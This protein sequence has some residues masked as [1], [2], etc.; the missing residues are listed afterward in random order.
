MADNEVELLRDIKELLK[1]QNRGGGGGSRG[2]YGGGAAAP[3]GGGGG[4]AI[5]GLAGGATKVVGGLDSLWRGSLTVSTS[6]DTL[7]KAIGNAGGTLG[8][9]FGKIASDV[10]RTMLD[11]NDAV[12]KSVKQGANFNNDLA[13]YDKLIKGARMTH[14]EYND[15][16]KKGA[17]DMRGLG[18]NINT[19]QK[20]FLLMAKAFQEGDIGARLKELGMHAEDLNE[21]MSATMTN[22]RG[23][24]M[25]DPTTKKSAIES[26]ER[27]LLATEE[28]ARLTGES[29]KDQLEAVKKHSE[30]AQMQMKLSMMDKQ[31]RE[32]YDAGMVKMHM[33]GPA[34]EKLYR[35]TFLGKITKEGQAAVTATG[36]SAAD[37]QRFAN[38][39]KDASPEGKAQAEKLGNTA[40]AKNIE[41]QN[42]VG[43]KN[44][45]MYSEGAGADM[46][47][48]QWLG[49]KIREPINAKIDEAKNRGED[50]DAATAYK[51]MTDAERK[52]MAPKS[53]E[54]QAQQTAGTQVATTI[55]KGD[56]KLS[57]L[58]AGSTEAFGSLVKETGNLVTDFG[59]L[60]KILA[61]MTQEEAGLSSLA[62]QFVSSKSLPEA[63][64][65]A[66]QDQSHEK[67]TGEQMAAPVKS[68]VSR[69]DGSPSMD[70]FLNGGSFS[71]M[72]E[73]FDP[74]GT[75][76]VLHGEE[77]VATRKQMEKF[78]E[79]IIPTP[80]MAQPTTVT[81][82]LP[83][84]PPIDF[85]TV[86]T[87]E[88]KP[89]DQAANAAAPITENSS[90]LLAQS[91]NS[92]SDQL[93]A[94]SS[95]LHN[96]KPLDHVNQVVEKVTAAQK[97]ATPPPA[98]TP[99]PVA[100]LKPSTTPAPTPAPVAAL[101]PSTTPELKQIADKLN[102]EKA[103]EEK[104]EEKPV[105]V[106]KEEP[107][108]LNLGIKTAEDLNKFI[109]GGMPVP[110]EP[111]KVD[112]D[113]LMEQG[114]A[115]ESFFKSN[116][117]KVNDQMQ[118][119]FKE[120]MPNPF[121]KLP[122]PKIDE[123]QIAD[124]VS[125]KQPIDKHFEELSKTVSSS[126]STK[127]V[128]KHDESKKSS[129]VIEQKPKMPDVSSL[130]SS[131]LNIAK[132]NKAMQSGDISKIGMAQ[133]D[134]SD[135]GKAAEKKLGPSTAS[136]A[137]Q[138]KREALENASFDY[139]EMKAAK[140]KPTAESA[141]KLAKKK[142]EVAKLSLAYEDDL[143]KTK[144]R[145]NLHAADEVKHAEVKN[146]NNENEKAQQVAKAL[147]D[148]KKFMKEH[149]PGSDD[150]SK[151]Q[152][153][154][155]ADKTVDNFNATKFKFLDEDA[156]SIRKKQA[157]QAKEKDKSP[158]ML[159]S[160]SNFFTSSKKPAFASGNVKYEE[161]PQ[162]EIDAK[163]KRMQESIGKIDN[164]PE[165]IAAQKAELARQA[166]SSRYKQKEPEKPKIDEVK[167]PVESKEDAHVK[168]MYKKYG[169]ETFKDYNARVSA[170]TTK[171]HA[172]IKAATENR[173]DLAPKDVA[174]PPPVQQKP[175]EHP[176]P[177]A[178]PQ[179]A[180]VPAEKQITLK[181]LH[182]ALI[183]LNKTMETMAHHT[184]QISNN[185][186]KQVSA[187][188]QLSNSRW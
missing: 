140:T 178:Q 117:E 115:A 167:K 119:K 125:K 185:S 162:A 183:K 57:D 34:A 150:K 101:K 6:F 53:A 98:P 60:D 90:K 100:A 65:D 145:L 120:M 169:F 146:K 55:N 48:Q 92:V 118:A 17:E 177:A 106:K 23:M 94:L 58:T 81:P 97:P 7:T 84:I 89:K 166:D 73:H 79:K 95:A 172:H 96:F 141:E 128:E 132:F 107:K 76:A 22:R 56:R 52:Q 88:A 87:E 1:Q 113:K 46:V 59:K 13:E 186:H 72:F 64:R 25:S 82:E 70:A 27:M 112:K 36:T 116:A 123:S 30:D 71:S 62:K 144:G 20:N 139:E 171:S 127:H 122:V 126:L 49:S 40:L 39:Q 16:V 157:E 143:I 45:G 155:D 18:S 103:K 99:A 114:K 69:A 158:G 78:V 164:S 131:L 67:T 5:G 9:A 111:E 54:E 19:S 24:D 91:L 130:D 153:K 109:F 85:K 37:I 80:K 160:I 174:P 142:E 154:T 148:E 74:A 21:V 11:T 26:S 14:E 4:D 147:A 175:V 133:M 86:P 77:L 75:P 181:D 134:L 47:R 121:D 42:S 184:D 176:Q 61:P 151:A 50:I 29:R 8:Q 129:S 124:A 105:E 138:K 31:A 170:E 161:I 32:R 33:L 44:F 41:W 51:R 104:K 2:S 43:A 10:G 159:D 179:A 163:N 66:R 152:L 15:M 135:A 156:E 35:D 136:I 110:K 182:E 173:K 180:L 165:A 187:T 68:T 168:E 3:S 93:K 38:A 28:I 149:G 188:K 108:L 83:P 12:N 102:T 63:L 137:L